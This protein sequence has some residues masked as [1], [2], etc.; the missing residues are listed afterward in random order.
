[1]E[2]LSRGAC[3]AFNFSLAVCL[4]ARLLVETI[5]T[6]L[7][8][9]GLGFEALSIFLSSIQVHPAGAQNLLKGVAYRVQLGHIHGSIHRELGREWVRLLLDCLYQKGG[10]D[11]KLYCFQAGISGSLCFSWLS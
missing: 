4:I 10:L 6:V 11:L 1:M 9:V 7:L 2:A 5:P 8:V 3:L